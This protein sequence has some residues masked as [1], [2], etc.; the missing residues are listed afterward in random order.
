[1]WTN[2]SGAGNDDVRQ[3]VKVNL[4]LML[5]LAS[6]TIMMGIVAIVLVYTAIPGG[7]AP[8]PTIELALGGVAVMLGLS[9]I[10][11]AF[12]LHRA[13]L[14]SA[15]QAALNRPGA[16]NA[17]AGMLGIYGTWLLIRGALFEGWGLLCG[18]ALLVT[19]QPLFLI[20]ALA[21]GGLILM[22][23]PSEQ[24][25]LHFE[26]EAISQAE[27]KTRNPGV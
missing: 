24:H 16:D 12:V 15:A 26:N 13:M 2:A 25:Y 3:A 7:A 1:M 6:G 10:G 5:A 9:S 8:D 27:L 18:V 21:A 4:M 20:G 11:G 23:L 14:G 17:R 22:R 19:G